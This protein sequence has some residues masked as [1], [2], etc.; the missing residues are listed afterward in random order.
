ML[1]ELLVSWVVLGGT[2]V[3]RSE[4][5]TLA[6]SVEA[7][8]KNPLPVA[9][10]HVVDQKEL[11]STLNTVDSQ[12]NGGT[13]T[14]DTKSGGLELVAGDTGELASRPNTEDCTNSEVGVDDG[15]S[16]KGIE[17]NGVSFAA[18]R[19]LNRLLF[20]RGSGDS[21]RGLQILKDNIVCQDIN[22]ELLISEG[23][24]AGLL[25]ARG[26]ANLVT[27]FLARREHGHNG[28]LELWL[29][30]GK[31]FLD[32]GALLGHS[33]RIDSVHL[34]LTS[35]LV[36]SLSVA[37]GSSSEG[38]HVHRSHTRLSH[39]AVHTDSPR[40]YRLR[41]NSGRIRTAE[42][43]DADDGQD[44]IDGERGLGEGEGLSLRPG[45]E[46]NGLHCF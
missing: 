35:R 1:E 37:G 24:E 21:T 25:V 39:E 34:E 22:G 20:R 18:H 7:L 11:V 5:L 9:G 40:A 29:T 12:G 32:R 15:R 16:I 30:L 46:S 8:G 23:V 44:R 27:D 17:G 38:C 13:R 42:R 4:E 26:R 3:S 33:W 10:G 6:D 28:L 36:V 41:K 14:V 45:D 43:V 2:K 19:N 31:E